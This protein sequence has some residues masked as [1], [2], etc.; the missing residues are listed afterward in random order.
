MVTYSKKLCW[1]SLIIGYY[2]HPP[3]CLN[4]FVF[5]ASHEECDV[6]ESIK[7]IKPSGY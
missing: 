7:S 6:T 4:V 5:E 1:S 3:V 2:Y